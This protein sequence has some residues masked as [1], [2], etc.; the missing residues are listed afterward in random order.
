MKTCLHFK[1]CLYFSKVIVG[2]FHSEIKQE[3]NPITL[4]RYVNQSARNILNKKI[5]SRDWHLPQHRNFHVLRSE[6]FFVD[7]TNFDPSVSIYSLSFSSGGF[8]V[9]KIRQ[10]HQSRC[11]LQYR[12]GK[13]RNVDLAISIIMQTIVRQL[14]HYEHSSKRHLKLFYK[15]KHN[16]ERLVYFREFLLTL[17]F[18]CLYNKCIHLHK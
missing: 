14:F 15:K 4:V 11:I 7:M 13:L 10:M 9:P 17:F 5:S 3:L 8:R 12:L 6:N 2:F 18:Y 1:A 16:G